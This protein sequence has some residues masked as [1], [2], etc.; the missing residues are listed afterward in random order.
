MYEGIIS[1]SANN[2]I[3]KKSPFEEFLPT[4]WKSKGDKGQ[5][6]GKKNYYLN[7]IAFLLFFFPFNV[8]IADNSFKSDSIKAHLL[9]EKGRAF[10]ADFQ[11]DSSYIHLEAAANLY[12]KNQQWEDWY[13]VVSKNATGLIRQLEFENSARYLQEN[14][15]IYLSEMDENDE[16]AAKIYGRMGIAFN[17]SGQ[18]QEALQ[19]YE[20]AL[21]IFYQLQLQTSFVAS[22]YKNTANIYTRLGDYDKAIRYFQKAIDIQVQLGNQSQLYVLYCDLS[23]AYYY[24]H[25]SEK[26][27]ECYQKAAILSD[28]SAEDRGILD[29]LLSSYYQTQSDTKEAM[30]YAQFALQK[31]LPTK[32]LNYIANTYKQ[33]GDLYREQKKWAEAQT[34]LEKAKQTAYQIHGQFHRETVKFHTG[35]G[36][37]YLAQNKLSAALKEYHNALICLFPKMKESENGYL[38]PSIQGFYIEPWIMTVLQYKGDVFREMYKQTVETTDLEKALECYELSLLELKMLQYDYDTEASKLYL[39]ANWHSHYEKALQVSVQLWEATQDS[40]YLENAFLW[41]EKSKANL[42]IEQLKESSA[43]YLNTMTIPKNYL[44]REQ[45]LK[46]QEYIFEELKWASKNAQLTAAYED[47]I[48]AVQ[49][50]HAFL[51]DTLQYLFPNYQS[52]SYNL[53]EIKLETLQNQL[54]KETMMVEYFVGDSS[55]YTFGMTNEKLFF[56]QIPKTDSLLQPLK[57]FVSL[58]QLQYFNESDYQKYTNTAFGIYETLLKPILE[59]HKFH[60]TLVIVPD[61]IL[62][63]IPFEALLT[64]SSNSEQINFYPNH[65]QYLIEDFEISYV[66]S[67]TLWL[68]SLQKKATEKDTNLKPLLAYAPIFDQPETNNQQIV[69]RRSCTENSLNQLK[70][71]EMEVQNI[72]Q[73]MGGDLYLRQEATKERFLQLASQYRILH[74]ATHA[75]LSEKGNHFNRIYFANQE[76]LSTYDFYGL[77]LQQTDL[78]TLSACNTGTGNLVNGEGFMSLSRGFFSAGCTSVLISLW[79]VPDNA[80]AEIM[81]SFYGYLHEGQSKSEALRNAKLQYLK[82]HE[83]EELYPLHWSAFVLM[84]NERAVFEDGVV[85]QYLGWIALFLGVFAVLGLGFLGIRKFWK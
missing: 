50:E 10:Y 15:D 60:S 34:Y 82:E 80:T 3:S 28:I 47:S 72:H 29:Q 8:L 52:S 59:Q 27:L 58:L 43:R 20:T 65:L 36:D 64:Q 56:E 37:Y 73:I 62:H 25:Q 32:N 13:A 9:E 23:T 22:I 11:Y 45:N 49:Q 83:D 77:D 76:A 26:E 7:L 33:I 44:E 17:K 21:Q 24:T 18:T 69:N 79:S 57:S 48:D 16:I 12:H 55:I 46:K 81:T 30:K 38:N 84:G 54:E 35:L 78:V 63:Y 14:L 2:Y 4:P 5:N 70:K 51:L 61:G 39:T 71:S 19:A 42:L 75:C 40:S 31:L 1:F 66:S 53:A 6:Q 41:A 85:W 68:H 74:L 67:A